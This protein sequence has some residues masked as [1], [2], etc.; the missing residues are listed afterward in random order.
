[1][2]E[3]SFV[4]NKLNLAEYIIYKY[5][6]EYN[7]RLISPIKLQ[8]GLYFLF[9]FWGG[10]IRGGK[11]RNDVELNV[12]DFH[13]Y[14]FSADFSAWKYGPVDRSIYGQFKQY[15]TI[16][17]VV[18]SYKKGELEQLKGITNKEY[19]FAK[20]YVDSYLKRIFIT[21]DFGL[22]DLSHKDNCWKRAFESDETPFDNQIN[23]EDIINEYVRP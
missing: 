9:A 1:M 3:I 4:F 8:K 23:S 10:Y 7:G 5:S 18:F 20:D 2:E 12:N 6:E 21:S 15:E 17:D 19:D 16:K 14:L 13:D 11:N 22:V